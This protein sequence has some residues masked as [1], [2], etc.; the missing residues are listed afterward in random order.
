M[1]PEEAGGALKLRA[2]DVDDLAV[3]SACLQDALIPV[4][5]IAYLPQ[6]KSF[7]FAANRFRW[8]A[9]LRAAMG[10]AGCERILSLVAFDAV[11][12]VLYRGFRR[13]ERER[14]LPLLAVRP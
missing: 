4:G 12:G 8:E 2:E 14:L 6:D 10:A 7:L 5:D 11:E 1:R 9:G 13:G 3:I